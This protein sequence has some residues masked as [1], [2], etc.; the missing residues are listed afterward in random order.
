[1]GNG[2]HVSGGQQGNGEGQNNN[3]AP[4]PI[5]HLVAATTQDLVKAYEAS[6][7]G[8]HKTAQSV[9][10]GAAAHDVTAVPG[11]GSSG[12]DTSGFAQL[13]LAAQNPKD[14]GLASGT[15][16]TVPESALHLTLNADLSGHGFGPTS[17]EDLHV[18]TGLTSVAVHDAHIDQ[19]A[20]AA[21]ALDHV[22]I[23]HH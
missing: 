23:V 10:G 12:H 20:L 8:D 11:N 3:Q 21:P 15:H 17:V 2:S 6:H 13:I 19:H 1:M 14:F 4:L 16:P 22:H 5:N 9:E 18:A 7:S